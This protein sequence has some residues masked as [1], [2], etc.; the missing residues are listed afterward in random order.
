MTE[1]I[2]IDRAVLQ[3]A[4]DVL[5][6]YDAEESTHGAEV[7]FALSDALATPPQS[8]PVAD[9]Q[10]GM[11]CTDCPSTKACKAGCVRQP[12]FISA[13]YHQREQAAVDRARVQHWPVSQDALTQLQ[14]AAIIYARDAG[15]T[16]QITWDGQGRRVVN[17]VVADE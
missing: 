2:T 8:Q 1:K 5:I 4:L 16:T 11:P 17:G 7:M 12:E 10:G 9:C 6:S 15:G 13:E 14:V 3:S